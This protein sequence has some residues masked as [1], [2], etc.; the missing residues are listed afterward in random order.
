M[1]ELTEEQRDDRLI[2][3][4]VAATA[5]PLPPVEEQPDDALDEESV[6]RERLRRI[7]LESA[8]IPVAQEPPPSL[9]SRVKNLFRR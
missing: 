3:D 5:V 6:I 1:H 2:A 7:R 4:P 8:H 9:L